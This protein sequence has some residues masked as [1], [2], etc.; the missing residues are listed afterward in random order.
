[1][2][3]SVL[4]S[5]VFVLMVTPVL[6][7]GG[8]VV[9]NA[10]PVLRPQLIFN[11]AEEEAA[12]RDLRAGDENSAIR[13]FLPRALEGDGLAQFAIAQLYRG[14]RADVGGTMRFPINRALGEVWLIRAAR[15]GHGES[16]SQLLDALAFPRNG[17]IVN[18]YLAYYWLD[19]AVDNGHILSREAIEL[20][21]GSDE[22]RQQTL[23]QLEQRFGVRP[24]FISAMPLPDVFRNPDHRL[25]EPKFH[26]VPLG[27]NERPLL[28]FPPAGYEELFAFFDHGRAVEALPEATRLAL[29]GDAFAQFLLGYA[30]LYGF[31][32][33]PNPAVA[34]LWFF[35]AQRQNEPNAQFFY[36]HARHFGNG[37]IR[38]RSEAYFLLH[39]SLVAGSMFAHQNYNLIA[40]DKETAETEGIDVD[41]LMN[42]R[43]GIEIPWSLGSTQSFRPFPETGPKIPDELWSR[44]LR[45]NHSIYCSDK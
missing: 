28:L 41:C 15:S 6:A 25:F 4:I 8:V 11:S 29:Q 37:V 17:S 34:A 13:Y 20:G 26:A 9:Q 19:R 35:K 1:M 22:S 27:S 39:R 32:I 18:P 5:L 10:P 33:E 12:W 7:Q 43:L 3:K 38:N 16:A 21:F 42:L 36:A 40:P 45:H 14:V 2:M 44:D 30:Y 31:G 24:P 23:Q